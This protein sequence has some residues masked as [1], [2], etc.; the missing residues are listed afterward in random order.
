MTAAVTQPDDARER[1]LDAAERLFY[2]RGVQAVGMDEIRAASGLALKRI[3][4]LYASKDELTVAFLQRRNEC[5]LGW[6]SAEVAKPTDRDERIL[7]VFDGLHSWFRQPGF[8]GCAWINVH[9]E[10]G[11]TVPA[12]AEAVREH[13]RAFR[14][15][16]ARLVA[17]AGRPRSLVAPIHLLAEGAMVTAASQCSPKP[18]LD[19]KAAA[20][21]LLTARAVAAG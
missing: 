6:L 14:R 17:D 12:V 16:I 11:A 7:A 10:L 9:G 5:W 1:L 8:R 19:A 2:S 3:Y 18:A 15:L 13:K 21:A 4:R 20:R